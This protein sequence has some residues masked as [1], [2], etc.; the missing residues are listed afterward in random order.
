MAMVGKWFTRRLPAAM[1]V[2]TVLL[3]FGMIASIPGIKGAA[4]QFGWRDTWAGMG[5]CLLIVL[6][7][8]AWLLVRST[9]ESVGIAPDRA[10]VVT[11]EVQ[12]ALETPLRLALR[13][14]GFWAFTL[15]ASLFNLVFSAITLLNENLLTSRGLDEHAYEMVMTVMVATGLP[16]N[17]ISGWL[18]PRLGMGKLLAIGMALLAGS[19]IMFPQLETTSQA[20]IFGGL[21]GVAGGIITVVWFAIYGHAFGRQN[22]GSIQAAAQLLAVLASAVGPL[23][24]AFVKSQNG[25]YDWFFHISAGAAVIL[26]LAVLAVKMPRAVAKADTPS[27]KYPLRAGE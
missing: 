21:L 16:A 3:T 11:E 17:L 12:V 8:V 18:A 2:F 4:E 10:V 14:P 26:A 7:P 1:S 23:A 9:P 15:S 22:L 19:L 13:L 5:W 6:A 24:L 27:P 25:S 20:L